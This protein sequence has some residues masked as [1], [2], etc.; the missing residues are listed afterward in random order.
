MNIN[1]FKGELKP[2]AKIEAIRPCPWC[3]QVGTLTVE[4]RR[5]SAFVTERFSVWCDECRINGPG[6]P[7]H[8]EAI[9]AWGDRNNNI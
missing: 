1:F 4:D 9:M 2:L 7:R 6:R 3:G 5:G 8:G